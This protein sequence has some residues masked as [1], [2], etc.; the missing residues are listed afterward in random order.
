MHLM[1]SFAHAF[2]LFERSTVQQA[3]DGL[4]LAR[5][6]LPK[7]WLKHLLGVK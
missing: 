3:C 1:N 2:G 4:A 5:F 7:L 6:D